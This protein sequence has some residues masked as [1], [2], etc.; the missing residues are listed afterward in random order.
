LFDLLWFKINGS[1][2]EK[3]EPYFASAQTSAN[4]WCTWIFYF[5]HVSFLSPS[6]LLWL[7]WPLRALDIIVLYILNIIYVSTVSKACL[8]E[9]HN[10]HG[11]VANAILAGV[12]FGLTQDQHIFYLAP[13][14]RG[15]YCKSP[16][17]ML[18]MLELVFS[19]W[20]C[21]ACFLL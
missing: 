21:V 1:P 18:M 15:M 11:R 19:G 5:R 8:H 9:V 6:L 10:K 7:A 3:Y 4:G 16:Y 17:T 13:C 12:L 14:G 20:G 2:V